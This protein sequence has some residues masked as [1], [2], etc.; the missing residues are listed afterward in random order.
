[1]HLS[2]KHFSL[3]LGTGLAVIA[4][5][6]CTSADDRSTA[7]TPTKTSASQSPQKKL[8]E[9]IYG[10]EN[11]GLAENLPGFTG[12]P[13]EPIT[14]LLPDDLKEALEADPVNYSPVV[15]SFT[16]TPTVFS[17]GYCV[18]DIDFDYADGIDMNDP[19]TWLASDD[20]TYWVKDLS[21]DMTEAGKVEQFSFATGVN[22]AEVSIVDV[23]PDDKDL[24][25]LTFYVSSDFTEGKIAAKCHT[26]H[27]DD[28][29]FAGLEFRNKTPGGSWGLEG[30]D[31]AELTVNVLLDGS[32]SLEGINVA[33]IAE[34]GVNGDWRLDNDR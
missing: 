32:I 25:E 21:D 34:R 10:F 31:T 24:E 4:L 14:V 27:G 12:E 20:A 7:D 15:D 18:L 2:K 19:T 6:G 9:T 30:E 22:W 16:L 13:N 17:T 23:M 1:M 29:D 28:Y 3:A 33:A 11:V 5:S 8:A 26:G